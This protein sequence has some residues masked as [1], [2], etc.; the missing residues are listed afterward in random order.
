VP[1]KCRALLMPS[2]P[3]WLALFGGLLTE[4][5]KYWN[6][7]QSDGGLT[8]EETVARVQEILT[9][10][11]TNTCE[12]C[13]VNDG[14]SPV[15]R[16]DANGH[17]QML[18][19]GYWV[20]PTGDYAIGSVAARTE[21]TADERR[22]LAAANAVFFLQ[23]TYEVI[24][25]AYGAG[26]G[27]LEAIANVV[28]FVAGRLAAFVPLWV[29]ALAAIG[30]IA[31]NIAFDAVEVATA[32]FWNDAFSERLTCIFY[33]NSVDTAGVVTF[34]LPGIQSDLIST[35][36]F[37]L[38]GGVYALIAQVRFLLEQVTVDGLNQA[39]TLTDVTEADCSACDD[40]WCYE[41]NLEDE[42]GIWSIPDTANGPAGV[43]ESGVGVR[44]NVLSDPAFSD[45]AAVEHD[46]ESLTAD[47]FSALV[48][49]ESGSTLETRIYAF[50]DVEQSNPTP[51]PDCKIASV[52]ASL[53]E[54]LNALVILNA[55]HGTGVGRIA[56]VRLGAFSGVNPFGDDNCTEWDCP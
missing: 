54:V 27:V 41:W 31:W 37:D 20:A 7:Q 17:P 32:D 2:D 47:Y 5:T 34:D 22:C 49:L 15:M 11:Y 51:S 35:A 3:E 25:D 36:G 44:F 6:F 29:S 8:V 56:R 1:D 33:T 26:L 39:G 43:W 23:Q 48:Y 13:V 42:L 12:P 19:A 24:T 18:E 53:A 14:D 45:Y 4:G 16:L 9:L 10:W 30:W 50:G 55:D 38:T 40:G 21:L 28:A 52:T 46:F